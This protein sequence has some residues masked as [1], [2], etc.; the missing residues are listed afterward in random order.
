MLVQTARFLIPAP[1]RF[2]QEEHSGRPQPLAPRFRGF[3][4]RVI[5]LSKCLIPAHSSMLPFDGSYGISVC[6]TI[7]VFLKRR[8]WKENT[9]LSL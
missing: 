7:R 4:F 5:C 2:R 3:A 6:R 1:F 8:P 9:I